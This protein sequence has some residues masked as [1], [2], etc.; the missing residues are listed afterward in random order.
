MSTTYDDTGKSRS[1][2]G[3]A[4]TPARMKNLAA[5]GLAYVAFC[6]LMLSLRPFSPTSILDV[7]ANEGDRLNQIGFL[8]AGSIV[9][10]GLITLVDR[11]K[12]AAY[13][14]PAWIGIYLVLALSIVV[15]PDPSAA[16]RSVILTLIGMLIASAII[17]LPPDEESFARMLAAAMLTLL[18]INYAGFALL[19]SLAI[20]GADAFEPQHAGLWRGSFTHKNIAGPVMSVFVMFGIYIY[21][22]GMRLSGIAVGLLAFIFVLKTGSKTTNGL[23]PM[24]IMVVLAGRI[25]G[26]SKLTVILSA[27]AVILAAMLTI[28][29]I[30]SDALASLTASIL[31]DPSF[32]G[33]FTLWKYGLENFSQNFWLGTGYD[34]FWGK[35]VVT[36]IEEPY[37]WAWDFRGIVHGHSNYVDMLVTLGVV[38][39]AIMVWA[40]YIM[41]AVN[42]V[43]ACRNPANAARADLFMMVIVFLA[44]LSFLETFFLRRVDPIWLLM[45]M[46]IMQLQVLARQEE[47]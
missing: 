40:I 37:E 5:T 8:A 6:L 21:R 13:V 7:E 39:F 27:L 38:G 20:H 36:G 28:G 23:L 34:S 24:A 41:P 26:L 47:R 33:R 16:M 4:L 42:Y 9:F 43:K 14:Q 3:P 29:T 44:L 19:P 32:T 31:D 22:R 11:K 25:F 17:L 15:A 45:V 10:I 2:A 12:L 35:P 46:A 18:F 1:A 30:Y